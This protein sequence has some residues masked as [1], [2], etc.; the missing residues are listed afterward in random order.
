MIMLLS[1]SLSLSC[2]FVSFLCTR[3]PKPVYERNCRCREAHVVTLISSELNWVPL[4]IA[5]ERFLQVALRVEVSQLLRTKEDQ[6]KD[7]ISF[8]RKE[9]RLEAVNKRPLWL[10]PVDREGP[11]QCYQFYHRASA[12][13][14]PSVRPVVGDEFI[15]HRIH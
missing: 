12:V 1:P 6:D 10:Q 3:I 5:E 15:G 11:I 7:Y 9:N 13:H 4:V 8:T 2:F 14:D